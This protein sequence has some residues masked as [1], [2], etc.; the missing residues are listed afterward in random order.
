MFAN[1]IT[2][3]DEILIGQIVDTNSAWMAE[4]LNL[5][6]IKVREILSI[7]DDP[8]HIL[9]TLVYSERTA[10]IT[11]ITGGLGPTKDDLTKH[12]LCKYYDTE[13]EF[14]ESVWQNIVRLFERF[15]REP[16]PIQRTQAEQPKAAT[17][18]PN[19][20]G[21]ASGMW[22]ERD[23]RIVVSMPGVPFEMQYLM[24]NEVLPRLVAQQK[25]VPITHRT[26]LTACVGESDLAEKIAA[27]EDA[28]PD[29]IKLAYLPSLGQVRL[30]L[31][32][33]HKDIDY[34]N[35]TIDA[36]TARIAALIPEHLFGTEK[37]SLQ[38]VIG[39]LL[40][41]SG[42]TLST[43]ESCTGGYIAHLITG[44]AGSS[45][46][47]NGGLVAYSNELK[48][49]YLGVPNTILETDGA[50]SEA[51]VSAM[52]EGSLRAYNTDFAL[53]VSGIA[54]PDGGTADKPVGTIWFAVASRRTTV[55]TKLKF[56]RDRQKN[57]LL[58]AV[59]VLNAL[60]QLIL[61]EQ[62]V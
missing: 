47:Y 24:Q 7:S 9:D 15:G 17:V 36:A 44:V 55:A 41:E 6:G 42:T 12:T 31:T 10:E 30:R 37:Q 27:E 11:L 48:I 29:F 57:I 32:G 54:G 14:N 51:C 34:L 50:V 1:L 22:F 33:R 26:L 19:K 2:I 49:K 52:A 28:L 13:L 35:T 18:L 53:A 39:D 43:A 45:A 56:G 21:T 59:W 3:G 20:V 8:Q 38:S 23:G 4:Q 5:N 62:D 60:R 61:A 58:T 40:R 16:K 25:G 46:Y